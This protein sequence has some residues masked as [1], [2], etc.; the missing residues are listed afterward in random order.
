MLSKQA[1]GTRMAGLWVLLLLSALLLSISTFLL[2]ATP[3]AHAQEAGATA[4]PVGNAESGRELFTGAKRFEN[5]GPPCMGCHSIGGI[6]ALG[7]GALG[8][9]LSR[10]S[11]KAINAILGAKKLPPTMDPIF[12]PTTGRTPI[13]PQEVADLA[14]FVDTASSAERSTSA[15][16]T[17]LAISVVVAAALVVIGHTM[18][19]NRA[20]GVRKP[21]VEERYQWTPWNPGGGPGH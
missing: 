17:L 1:L 11:G 6:G 8:P 15:V 4:A 10:L 20:N 14:A 5:G 13:T 3:S 16:G 21:M 7:G 9:D 18:W 2:V 19:R 12:N